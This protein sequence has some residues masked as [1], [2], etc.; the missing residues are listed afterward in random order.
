[1]NIKKLL[2]VATGLI[3][4]ASAQAASINDDRTWLLGFQASSGT[5]ADKN[6]II[7]LGTVDA[8][9]GGYGFN[10]DFSASSSI[11][12]ST[13]GSNWWT[14]SNLSW[15]L[16]GSDNTSYDSWLGVVGSINTAPLDGGALGSINSGFA[17]VQLAATAGNAG[18][19]TVNDTIGT[20]HD[21]SV[22]PTGNSGSWSSLVASPAYGSL[23]SGTG[24]GPVNTATRMNVYRFSADVLGVDGNDPT[25]AAN[26]ATLAAVVGLNNGVITVVPEPST[27]CLLGMAGLVGVLYFRRRL[28]A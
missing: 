1:M 22:S 17:N 27:Y 24:D 3:G 12:S 4:F 18:I 26:P 14:R 21:V 11:L 28:K 13:Y 6:V 16:L 7:N 25:F 5:G 8:I 19:S 2:L 10:L 15:G 9:N 20:S 23:Y